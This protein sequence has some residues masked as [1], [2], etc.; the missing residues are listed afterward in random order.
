MALQFIL[1]GSGS[2]KTYD[3]QKKITGEADKYPH[4]NYFFVVPEQFTM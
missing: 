3:I 4:K 2:G 1:G